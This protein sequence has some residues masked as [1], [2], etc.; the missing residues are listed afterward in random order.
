MKNDVNESDAADERKIDP[1]SSS[2]GIGCGVL[3]KN[4]GVKWRWKLGDMLL[5]RSLGE[6]RN[7]GKQS[8]ACG[9]FQQDH[10]AALLSLMSKSGMA[11]PSN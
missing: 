1:S 8:H 9:S 3:V 2:A 5:S 10:V 6:L 11:P 7:K 4:G